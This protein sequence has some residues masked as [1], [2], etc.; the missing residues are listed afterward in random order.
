ML[1]L[2]SEVRLKMDSTMMTVLEQ[3]QELKK[4]ISA[5]Q[6]NLAASQEELQM[7]MSASQDK[8]VAYQY[9]LKGYMCLPRGTKGKI[10]AKKAAQSKFE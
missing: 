4:G 10:S 5:G 3:L 6:D 1:Q 2:L 9:T 8:L 7:D